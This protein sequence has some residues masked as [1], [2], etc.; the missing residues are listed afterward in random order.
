MKDVSSIVGMKK[1]TWL[2][3]AVLLTACLGPAEKKLPETHCAY[4]RYFDLTE[5]GDIVTISPYDG[6]RDTLKTEGP[7]DNLVCMSTSHIGYLAGLGCDSV[8][9]AVSGIGYVSDPSLRRRHDRTRSGR[10]AAACPAP[11]MRADDRPLYDVGYEAALDYERIMTLHPDLLLTYA[12]SSAEPPYIGKLRDLGVPVLVLHEQMETHPL[13]RAEYVRLFGALTG[14]QALADS[15]FGAIC[16]RYDSLRVRPV[17]AGEGVHGDAAPVPESSGAP[18]K[19]LLNMPYGDQWF[20]PGADNYIS[21]LIRDAGGIVLGAK[22]GT[23]ASDVISMEEGY[24]LARQADVWLHPGWCRSRAQLAAVNP[25]FGRFAIADIYNN[26]LRSTSEGGNDFWESGA[27][28]ADRILE[29]LVT[30]LQAR[31]ADLY[32]YL[33]VE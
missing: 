16:R 4:A 6:R 32:Y 26:T 8:V 25:L 2:V 1:I 28:R 12:V 17:S 24:V 14:R 30:I 22:E 7:S 10:A 15:L 33:P 27:L 19:V 13:A 18:K 5:N 9:S 31:P 21:T 20:I 29:D 11:G 3:G 23:A